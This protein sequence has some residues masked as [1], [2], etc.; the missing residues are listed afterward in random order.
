MADD[1]RTLV[2]E[3]ASEAC[4]VALFEDGK[5]LAGDHRL[6]GR[7]HAELLVP[8]ISALPGKGKAGRILVSLGP[9]SFTGVRIGIAVARALGVAWHAQVLGYPTLALVAAVARREHP[10]QPVSV[11]MRGGHGEIFLQDFDASGMPEGD[12]ASLLPQVAATSAMH[13]IIAGNIA[14]DVQ[15]LR[16]H[17]EALSLHP[18]A[19]HALNLPSQLLTSNLAPTYGRAPDAKL[20]AA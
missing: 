10:D 20:P 13:G 14:Q 2:V 5:L 15:S 11:A 3:C 8:M 6:L 19:R 18:D 4:S 12:V 7:G 17:G 1:D 9:G 16:G